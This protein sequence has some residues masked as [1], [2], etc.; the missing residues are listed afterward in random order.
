[1]NVEQKA[2]RSISIIPRQGAWI[3]VKTPIIYLLC[4]RLLKKFNGSVQVSSED[5]AAVCQLYIRNEGYK[6]G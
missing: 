3:L 2:V 4:E 1:M 6:E 5:L